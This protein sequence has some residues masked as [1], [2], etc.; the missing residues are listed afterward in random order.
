MTTIIIPFY[1]YLNSRINKLWNI[2]KIAK[3]RRLNFSNREGIGSNVLAVDEQ[4]R[5]LI[6]LK[7]TPNTS[8]CLLIDL[9]TLDRCSVTK[10]YN[11]IPAGYLE[12]KKLS[13]FLKN[14][15]LNLSFKNNSKKIILP[16]YQ[17]EKDNGEDVIQLEA[18]A[19]KW[20]TI[21]S[22]FKLIELIKSA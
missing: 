7:N 16:L 21:I 3:K 4:K 1:G 2:T 19:K 10:E 18:K 6:Y 5:K 11:S 8:S 13:H 12:N 15:L 17:A 22:K 9:S 14:I 20:E